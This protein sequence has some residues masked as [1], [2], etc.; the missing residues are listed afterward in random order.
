[1]LRPSFYG[2]HRSQATNCPFC[3]LNK[4]SEVMSD[5]DLHLYSIYCSQKDLS[6]FWDQQCSWIFSLYMF[7][8]PWVREGMLE[9]W[10][11][12]G[13]NDFNSINFFLCKIHGEWVTAKDV[14]FLFANGGTDK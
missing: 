6:C 10:N 8:F 11:F 5:T 13:D 1:M 12:Y 14:S 2:L 9:V 7:S 3:F 4:S